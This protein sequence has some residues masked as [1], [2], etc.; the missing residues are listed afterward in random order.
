MHSPA[1]PRILSIAG[2]DSS[3]GAGIQADIKTIAMRGGYAMTAV[4][5]ITAQ[6]TV[7]VQG[8]A[9]IAPD[10]V[11]LQI[12]ACMDDIGVDAI[13]IGMLHDVAV[14]E[15]VAGA[16]AGVAAPI[17]LDPVMIATS[18]AALIAPEAVSALRAV[19]FPRAALITPNLPELAHLAGRELPSVEAMV[20]A[21]EE[22]AVASGAAVLAKGGHMA[23]AGGNIM[24]GGGR[25][26][27]VLIVPGEP[28]RFYDHARLG[29]RH[30]HG[31]GCTLS[32]AIATM[33]G[34]GM[35]LAEAVEQA[36]RFVFAAIQ[37]APGYG[38]GHGPLGHQA[39]R[40]M[41]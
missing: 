29:T 37:A 20:H 40:G 11:A 4:T 38:A 30:T 1:P 3:G 25:I 22:L 19:L 32:S 12:A 6:N 21:A 34:R 18:G 16:L 24:E 27:D 10:L 26:T 8:I 41:G 13:K 9:A 5:A 31:T 15:A 7:G 33:L 14:I 39:V 17:V 28:P 2:S 23:E 36:R 35:G